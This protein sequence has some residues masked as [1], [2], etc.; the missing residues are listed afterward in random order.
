MFHRMLRYPTNRSFFL[1]GARG[2]GKTTLLRQ[3]LQESRSLFIDLLSPSM[4]SRLR[5]K[6]E[7]L[8]G[9]AAEAGDKT[10]VLDEIQRL[11]A[12][13]DVAHSL[14]SRR[15]GRFIFTG[16]SSRKLKRGAA[17]LLGGRAAVRE[18][19]PLSAL[20]IGADFDLGRALAWGT[21]PEPWSLKRDEDRLDF[22]LAY[23]QTYLREEIAAEQLVRRV[24]AFR[25]FLEVAAQSNAKLVNAANIA[26]DTGIDPK[27]VQSYFTILE[28]TNL[29]FMLEQHHRSARKR[30]LSMPKFYF[31]DTGVARALSTAIHSPVVEG[32]SYFG[33]CF[34]HFL[35]SELR[36]L[37]SYE[38]AGR[39]LQTLA[40]SEGFEIDLVMTKPGRPTMLVEIKS[41][42]E[43]D[44]RHA[45]ALVLGAKDFPEDTERYLVS[46]DPIARVENGITYLPWVSFLRREFASMLD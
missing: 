33:E 3:G 31:F 24:D 35:V 44:E 7:L 46:R 27:T 41:T 4:E 25:G 37:C 12:L 28:D 42:T 1:F 5:R 9:I 43:A 14:L 10:I 32:T 16:S 29:G 2:T 38:N 20:E 40:T 36:K 15:I 17:N 21:L 8:E 6:P 11:P 30:V 26:R 18:L 22:L 45:K 19:F 23:G 13:L 39:R 34:E